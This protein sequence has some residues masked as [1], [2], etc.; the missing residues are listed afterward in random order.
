MLWDHRPDLAMSATACDDRIA[1]ARAGVAALDPRGAEASTDFTVLERRGDLDLVEARPRTGRTH[2]VRVH[3]A[4]LGCPLLA[5]RTYG[6]PPRDAAVRAIAEA[7][8]R[9]ALHARTLAFVHP[10]TGEKLSFTSEL[11]AD[12]Q[13]ALAALRALP[14]AEA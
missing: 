1:K 8:G 10:A 13:A 6:R 3:L 5:D 14:A 2:Q 11:P 9:Q 4:A 7:L 12:M